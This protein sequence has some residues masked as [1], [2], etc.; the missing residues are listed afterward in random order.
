M[1]NR[2]AMDIVAYYLSEFDDKAFGALGFTNRTKG[3]NE[4]ASLFGK[5][6]NYL[7]RLRDEYDVVTSSTRRGQCNRP[8][9]SRII[10]TCEYLRQ[11][12]FDELT[13]MVKALV[14]NVQD[15]YTEELFDDDSA[16]I[17]REISEEELERALNAKDP[18][19]SISVRVG[20]N[21]IRIY[22][23]AIINQ[24]KRL[25]NGHCQLCGTVPFENFKAVD[26]CE[27]HH[28]DYFVSSHNNDASNIIIVCP[29]HHRLIHK[30]NPV[31]N[32]D[33]RCFEYPDG[34]REKIKIDYIC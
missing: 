19:A 13:D 33:D 25:Y 9:R 28:I 3:F 27:A 11:F 15:N 12:S 8:P 21:K 24:L 17:Y 5:G 23:T 2:K 20:T 1:E 30:L 18:A 6:G 31:F 4:I 32:P 16:K 26:I 34:T 22:K 7:R 29:N 10:L 14:E